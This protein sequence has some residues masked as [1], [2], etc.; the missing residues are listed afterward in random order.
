LYAL[1]LQ[2]TDLHGNRL[3]SKDISGDNS[4]R[5]RQGCGDEMEKLMPVVVELGGYLPPEP[6][7]VVE[8]RLEL[9]TQ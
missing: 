7:A 5:E 4:L 1:Y 3:L 2:C 9:L 8:K 6:R